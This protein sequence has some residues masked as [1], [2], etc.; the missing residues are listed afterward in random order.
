MLEGDMCGGMDVELN[1]GILIADICLKVEVQ[2]KLRT[3]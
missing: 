2:I 1:A 3:R